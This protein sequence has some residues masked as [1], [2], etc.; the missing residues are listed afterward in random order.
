MIAR[1]TLGRSVA[2]VLSLALTQ[3]GSLAQ[4]A[5]THVV[6]TQQMAG[7][8]AERAAER[9]A[10][11][12]LVQHALDTEAARQ[13][14]SAMGLRLDRMRAAVPHLSDGELQDLSRRA[15]HVNDVAAGHHDDDGLVILALI[16]LLAGLA[17]LAA[18]GDTGYYD[19]C[20]CY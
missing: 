13:Q 17:I 8:L 19:D 12:K 3:V 10:Q 11:V 20:G 9:E 14:A 2:V 1:T 16:L 15:E 6:D 7:R 5:T 4:A 18:V